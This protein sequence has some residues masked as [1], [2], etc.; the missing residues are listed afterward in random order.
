MDDLQFHPSA[1]AG[2]RGRR[3]QIAVCSWNVEGLSDIKLVQICLYMRTNSVDVMILQE[4]RKL[5]S[6][7]FCTDDGYDVYLSSPVRAAE[8]GLVLAL[9]WHQA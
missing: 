8:S 1:G 9:S 2:R 5:R 6:D 7:R 3:K 4:T